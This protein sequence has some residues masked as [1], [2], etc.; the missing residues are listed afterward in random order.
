MLLLWMHYKVIRVKEQGK[1]KWGERNGIT[2][3]G[4]AKLNEFYLTTKKTIIRTI[5]AFRFIEYHAI[6]QNELD[7]QIRS[8]ISFF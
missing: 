7:N 6:I 1:G 5:E 3:R 2:K 4:K 8:S